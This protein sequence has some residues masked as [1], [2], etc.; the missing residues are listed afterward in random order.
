MYERA[1]EH[2][3]VLI[4]TL[5]PRAQINLLAH[6]LIDRDLF[7]QQRRQRLGVFFRLNLAAAEISQFNVNDL[8][9]QIRNRRRVFDI[10]VALHKTIGFI[11]L[12]SQ[13]F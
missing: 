13:H 11:L 7:R 2:C 4:I 12:A 3:V 1:A 8:A 5:R 9:D 6:Q 10:W